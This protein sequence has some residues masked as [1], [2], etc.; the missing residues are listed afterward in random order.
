MYIK[1]IDHTFITYCTYLPNHRVINASAIKLF[2]LVIRFVFRA[3][4]AC[5]VLHEWGNSFCLIFC[6]HFLLNIYIYTVYI[7]IF[8]HGIYVLLWKVHYYDILFVSS[9]GLV[10]IS[11]SDHICTK[12]T[13]PVIITITYLY[14][15]RDLRVKIYIPW[16]I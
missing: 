14:A 13:F 2:C 9:A 12:H 4:T 16:F 8:L 5:M 1:Y 15:F 6:N 11:Y 7:Y 3:S 10:D